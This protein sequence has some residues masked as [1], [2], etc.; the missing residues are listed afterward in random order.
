M[1][2]SI[3]TVNLNN[4]EGLKKTI[5]SIVS[6]TFT[7]FEWIVIDGGSTDGSKELIEEYSSHFAYWVSE[8]DKGIYNAMNKGIV[9]AQGEFLIFM[10]SGDSFASTDVLMNVSGFLK[11]ADIV[12]GDTNLVN[13]DGTYSTLKYPEDISMRQMY[14]GTICHQASFI[15]KTLFSEMKY[16]ERLRIV[17]DWEFFVRMLIEDKTFKHIPFVICDYAIDGI[18]SKDSLV[19]ERS[20]LVNVLFPKAIR[21]DF[22]SIDKVE[23]FLANTKI[24]NFIKLREKHPLLGKI[25]TFCVI[26]MDK[27]EK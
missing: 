27:F 23:S 15:R 26:L 20:R 11:D 16:N 17:S 24:E 18:S 21:N 10:N 25:I 5:D 3:I 13:P 1:N 4:L 12:Y 19:E 8:P 7:D 22:Q 9:V 6:Q 14:K 2:L